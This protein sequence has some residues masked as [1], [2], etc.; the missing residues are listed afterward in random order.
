MGDNIPGVNILG[1]NFPG[2]NFQKKV[3]WVGIIWME[4]PPGG[5][6]LEPIALSALIW[7]H[8]ILIEKKSCRKEIFLNI[9]LV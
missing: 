3:W 6:F 2:G 8:F 4:I 5:I 7:K 1:G 9:L